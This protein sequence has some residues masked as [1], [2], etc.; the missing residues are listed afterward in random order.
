ML[1]AMSA[2]NRCTCDASVERQ[3]RVH[4]FLPL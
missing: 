1:S 4:T 3:A 2:A